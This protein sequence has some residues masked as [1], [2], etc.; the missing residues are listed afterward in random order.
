MNT[1][2]ALD[3]G[4]TSIKTSVI[5]PNGTLLTPGIYTLPFSCK[6]R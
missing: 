1:F 4:G 5:T 6:R 3:V 2:I